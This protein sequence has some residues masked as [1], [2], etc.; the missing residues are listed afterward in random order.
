MAEIHHEARVGAN[1][2]TRIVE[3][4]ER[5]AD[6]ATDPATRNEALAQVIELDHAAKASRV[7]DSGELEDAD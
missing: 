1:A 2:M 4:M 5:K 6:T 7:T 3:M